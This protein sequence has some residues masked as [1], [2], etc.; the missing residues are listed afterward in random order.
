[1]RIAAPIDRKYFVPYAMLWSWQGWLANPGQAV[2]RKLLDMTWLV[3]HSA[4]LTAHRIPRNS[5]F[6]RKIL[7]GLRLG[8]CCVCGFL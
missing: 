4:A 2:I 7:A 1:M 6:E 8:Y 3:S 5:Q